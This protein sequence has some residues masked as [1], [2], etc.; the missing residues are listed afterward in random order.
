MLIN[1]PYHLRQSV[2]PL[3][4]ACRIGANLADHIQLLHTCLSVTSM[5]ES[6]YK[7][8]HVVILRPHFLCLFLES[9]RVVNP[10]QCFFQGLKILHQLSIS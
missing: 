5:D 3:L 9:L 7:L 4:C 1:S 6:T 10:P 8:V 2:P